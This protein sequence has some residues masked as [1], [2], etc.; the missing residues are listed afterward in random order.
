MEIDG[1]F[2]FTT[3]IAAFVYALC[4]WEQRRKDFPDEQLRVPRLLAVLAGSRSEW[5]ESR[6]L[7]MQIGMASVPLWDLAVNYRTGAEEHV[8]PV[9]FGGLTA[10]L[11]LFPL[12]FLAKNRLKS[13]EYLSLGRRPLELTARREAAEHEQFAGTAASRS[14]CGLLRR[15]SSK[16][17]R[18]RRFWV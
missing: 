12:V 15:F 10:I 9:A 17:S 13:A 8:Y 14:W 11:L 7:S 6:T 5:V 18:I 1:R 4:F 16:W 2:W 3:V